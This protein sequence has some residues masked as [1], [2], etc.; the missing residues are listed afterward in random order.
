MVDK[1]YK[2]A[3]MSAIFSNN[4]LQLLVRDAMVVTQHATLSEATYDSAGA[5]FSGVH[6]SVPYP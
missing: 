4:R 5:V 1:A 3:G 6:P 2:V